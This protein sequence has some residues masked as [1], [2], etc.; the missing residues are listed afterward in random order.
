MSNHKPKKAPDRGNFV[1]AA[2]GWWHINSAV[3]GDG[4]TFLATPVSGPHWPGRQALGPPR[5]VKL[6]AID[7]VLRQQDM[8]GTD[9]PTDPLKG[10][11]R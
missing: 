3:W 4:V 5:V 7:E 8:G 2:G 1:R 11:G 10:S 6:H 9:D